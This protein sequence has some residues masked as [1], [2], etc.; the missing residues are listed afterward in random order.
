[1]VKIGPSAYDETGPL[2]VECK[3]TV[4]TREGLGGDFERNTG[5]STKEKRITFRG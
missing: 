2:L 1:M 5:G 4:E 3:F